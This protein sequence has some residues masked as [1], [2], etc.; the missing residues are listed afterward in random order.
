MVLLEVMELGTQKYGKSSG[1]KNRWLYIHFLRK[2]FD[3]LSIFSVS[4]R[5]YLDVLARASSG[6]FRQEVSKP[7]TLAL[8][9]PDK[10]LQ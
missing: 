5:E 4:R 1:G 8:E 10:Y 7:G 6:P 2:R 9:T 3:T